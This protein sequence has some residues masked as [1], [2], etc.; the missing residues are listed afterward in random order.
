[1]FYKY[2]E[3]GLALISPTDMLINSSGTDI[4]QLD[5]RFQEQTDPSESY[6]AEFK[7]QDAIGWFQIISERNCYV[8]KKVVPS[9]K[10]M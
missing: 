10:G 6:I 8:V 1:M 9:S 7:W 2:S 4:Y 3:G 5:K